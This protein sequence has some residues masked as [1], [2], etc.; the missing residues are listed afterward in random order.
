MGEGGGERICDGFQEVSCSKK[1]AHLG[2]CHH[3]Q[4]SQV[5][6]PTQ[7]EKDLKKKKK[8]KRIREE[9]NRR[10]EGWQL[11][12]SAIHLQSDLLWL[13]NPIILHIKPRRNIC[14]NNNLGTGAY[15]KPRSISVPLLPT[16]LGPNLCDPT[17]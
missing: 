4:L 1:K 9:K 11:V 6:L 14:N 15:N 13:K 10:K 2:K 5:P 8:A 16:G 7:G 17:E 3:L 12:K